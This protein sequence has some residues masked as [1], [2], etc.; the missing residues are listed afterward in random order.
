LSAASA[1]TKCPS[2]SNATAGGC[3]VQASQAALN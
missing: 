3:A 2:P 1:T